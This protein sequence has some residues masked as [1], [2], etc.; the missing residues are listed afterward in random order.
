M[1]INW[2]GS[3]ISGVKLYKDLCHS[4]FFCLSSKGMIRR[5]IVNMRNDRGREISFP[6]LGLRVQ[7]HVTGMWVCNAHSAQF[8]LLCW[9]SIKSKSLHCITMT[10]VPRRWW[11]PWAC[12]H[13]DVWKSWAYLGQS[14]SRTPWGLSK[15]LSKASLWPAQP[16]SLHS[17]LMHLWYVDSA[18]EYSP[19]SRTAH[20]PFS[21]DMTPRNPGHR[22]D[23]I[24]ALIKVA[25]LGLNWP[26][27]RDWLC[28]SELITPVIIK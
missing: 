6:V 10:L 19:F 4:Q 15:K 26:V 11:K 5:W 12:Y 24:L 1:V 3:L 14:L 28:V 2:K 27:F 21:L 18:S 8:C 9:I 16:A 23:L 25:E 13:G 17:A 20:Q 7:M 22:I